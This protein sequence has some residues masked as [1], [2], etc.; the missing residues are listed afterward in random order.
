M[1]VADRLG[2]WPQHHRSQV[3]VIENIFARLDDITKELKSVA[4][5]YADQDRADGRDG[6]SK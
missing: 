2:V 1:S 5:R 3:Q 6:E 4:D